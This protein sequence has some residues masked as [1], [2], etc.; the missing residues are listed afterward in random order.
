LSATLGCHGSKQ[1]HMLVHIVCQ[2]RAREQV[3]VV[4]R[5]ETRQRQPS[6]TAGRGAVWNWHDND[7]VATFK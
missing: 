5:C 1:T 7:N 4:F 2:V 6:H 3:V